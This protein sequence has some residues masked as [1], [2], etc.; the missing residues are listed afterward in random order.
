MRQWKQL[1]LFTRRGMIVA[2]FG[3][4][5]ICHEGDRDMSLDRAVIAFAGVMILLSVALT[6]WVSPLWMWFTVFIG[7]NLLQSAFTG[8]CPAA[9]VFKKLGLR[10]GNAFS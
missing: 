7:L 2:N 1:P 6:V 9:N 8:W 5:P 4:R 3:V 10:A